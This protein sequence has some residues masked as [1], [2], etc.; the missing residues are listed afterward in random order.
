MLANLV[1]FQDGRLMTL[2][3]FVNCVLMLF[4]QYIQANQYA[5]H[6]YLQ[7][8]QQKYCGT[9]QNNSFNN[10]TNYHYYLVNFTLKININLK[11]N[12]FEL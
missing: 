8:V 6:Q 5:I 10:L 9:S 1:W 3:D 4:S 11:F 7:S 12:C 2:L